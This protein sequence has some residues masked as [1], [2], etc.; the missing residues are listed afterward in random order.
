MFRRLLILATL[1]IA[2]P[3]GAAPMCFPGVYGDA[4]PGV[5]AGRFDRGWYAWGFCKGKDGEPVVLYRLCAHGECAS[6]IAGQAGRT[7]ATLGAQA[8]GKDP[9]AVYG[10]WFDANQPAYHCEK[11]G[12][13]QV[14]WPNTARGDACAE[15][16]ALIAKT[17]P[18]WSPPPTPVPAVW[19][20]KKNPQSTAAPTTRP[21][22]LLANGV[23]GKATSK[24]ATE[25]ETCDTTKPTLASGSD[26]WASYGASPVAGEVA[27]CTKAAP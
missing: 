22:Y 12:G 27:L 17:A 2:M 4:Y 9:K 8:I 5:Y 1:L 16:N 11:E 19:K 14:L 10:A 3:A 7:M 20:V 25:G 21:V 24:R 6:D 13:A 15:L 26:L 18:A 23:L